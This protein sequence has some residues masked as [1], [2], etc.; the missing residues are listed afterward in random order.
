MLRKLDYSVTFPSTLRTFSETVLFQDGFGVVTGANEAGKSMII[1]MIRFALFGTNALRG[2]TEDYKTLKVTLDLSI[3]GEPYTVRR[4][5]SIAKLFRNDDQIAHGVTAVNSKIVSELGFGMDVFDIGCVANQDE[6]MK[7]GNMKPTERKRIVDSVIG[8]GVLDDLT[9]SA[10]SEASGLSRRASDLEGALLAPV[11]P[12]TPA[13]YAPS[14]VLKEQLDQL[15]LLKAEQDRLTGELQNAVQKPQKPTGDCGIGSAILQDFVD[16]QNRLKAERQ[17][18]ERQIAALPAPSPYTEEHLAVFEAQAQEYQRHMEKQRFLSQY[19]EPMIT[20]TQLLDDMEKAWTEFENQQELN[21]ITAQMEQLAQSGGKHH[22]PSCHHEWLVHQDVYQALEEK[23]TEALARPRDDVAPPLRRYEIT[24]ARRTLATWEQAAEQWAVV[25]DYPDTAVKPQLTLEG[26][27][28]HRRGNAAGAER[29]ALEAKLSDLVVAL[30]KQPDYAS[31]L[32]SQTVYEAMMEH[33]ADRYQG[34]E[35]WMIRRGEIQT[36]MLMLEVELQALAV[37]EQC[38]DNARV[39]EA[40]LIAHSEAQKR[41]DENMSTVRELRTEADDWS[42]VRTALTNLR[43]KIKQH[44]VPSLNKVASSLLSQMT[45]GQR[46]L[47]EVDE[48][49]NILIDNQPIDTL[50][51][52]GKA[53]ANLAIRLGLG[54]VL[55]NNVLSLFM[56]DEI[57]GSFDKDRAENTANALQTLRRKISQ[58]LIVTHKFTPADYRINVGETGDQHEPT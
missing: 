58:I 14:N 39:Y 29:P 51:G 9:K 13:G 36:R 22:C 30:A 27:D 38:Y 55:T 31:M 57:D 48:E 23:R 25:K 16:E 45:G 56:G 46:Q 20:N 34:W 33:W 44:L 49:F 4:T 53:V 41:W 15:R 19:E 5:I 10:A 37:V 7:L 32:R 42:K 40:A 8:L 6:L 28:Q 50:S 26:I 47:V 11:H 24:A 2:R 12:G 18:L 21:R 1:E 3:K 17:S 52:S 54:Q 43:A 35:T